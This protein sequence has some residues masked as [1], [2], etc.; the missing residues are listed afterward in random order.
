[1][2]SIFGLKSITKEKMITG[3]VVNAFLFNV[4][5]KY[6]I[7]MHV[8]GERWCQDRLQQPDVKL[9]HHKS[10]VASFRMTSL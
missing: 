1:M 4:A 9:Q 10:G 5:L 6:D 2:K 3:V 8:L 7:I